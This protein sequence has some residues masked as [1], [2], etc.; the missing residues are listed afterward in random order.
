VSPIDYDVEA[1]RTW[2]EQA[3]ETDFGVV[4]RTGNGTDSDET[5]RDGGRTDRNTGQTDGPTDV[6][7]EET[8]LAD[9]REQTFYGDA[10]PADPSV[11]NEDA[12]GTRTL[13][14]LL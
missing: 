1:V 4:R 9:L 5:D 7:G 12:D 3:I 14:N 2:R 10:A 6:A 8:T 13:D 11:L